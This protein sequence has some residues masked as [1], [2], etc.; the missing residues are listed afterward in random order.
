MNC[1][2]PLPAAQVA[3]EAA[4]AMA[5]AIYYEMRD[6]D[7]ELTQEIKDKLQLLP[8]G[9]LARFLT[10]QK[11]ETYITYDKTGKSKTHKLA[12]AKRTAIMEFVLELGADPNLCHMYDPDPSLLALLVRYGY[13]ELT[14]KELRERTKNGGET[15]YERACRLAAVHGTPAPPAPQA[16]A[17]APKQRTC[18]HCGHVGTGHSEKACW[19]VALANAEA[20]LARMKTEGYTQENYRRIQKL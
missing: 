13:R 4:K 1:L 20:A 10:V 19:P 17:S 18:T 8:I 9:N 11:N 16:Q 14:L 2:N 15:D 6:A 7:F 5:E 12:L 3:A